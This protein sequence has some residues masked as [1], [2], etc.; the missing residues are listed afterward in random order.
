MSKLEKIE[1]QHP[2]TTPIVVF[3]T[4]L[5]VPK[6]VKY[7]LILVGGLRHQRRQR[8]RIFPSS[9]MAICSIWFLAISS[10]KRLAQ[11]CLGLGGRYCPTIRPLFYAG[12]LA[13]TAGRFWAR[14][15]MASQVNNSSPLQ[16][17]NLYEA[18]FCGIDLKI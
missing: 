7:Q 6:F 8:L 11:T 16:K 13:R 2:E 5:M 17:R 14:V 18:T 12:R 4:D 15:H 10:L 3:W 9:Q 1:S